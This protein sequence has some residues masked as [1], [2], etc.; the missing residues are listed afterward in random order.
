[1]ARTTTKIA[2]STKFRNFVGR[3][4]LGFIYFYFKEE[5]HNFT[6]ILRSL[7]IEPGARKQVC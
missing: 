2:L 3:K 1:M 5:S 6:E 7:G 4:E